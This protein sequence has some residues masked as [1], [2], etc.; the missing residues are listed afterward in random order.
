MAGRA[1][2]LL[3]ILEQREPAFLGRRQRGLAREEGVELAVEPVKVRVLDLVLRDRGG[4]ARKG[5]IGVV[6]RLRAEDFA[7]ARRIRRARRRAIT[8]AGVAFAISRA[9]RNGCFACSASV[10]TRPSRKK[11]PNAVPSSS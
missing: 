4:E 9:S 10:G 5:R 2:A 6:E 11:P 1:I 8:S 7:K 3:R